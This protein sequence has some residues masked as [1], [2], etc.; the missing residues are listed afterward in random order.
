MREDASLGDQIAI[1]QLC[2]RFV[3]AYGVSHINCDLV[4]A[5]GQK[6]RALLFGVGPHLCPILA[7]PRLWPAPDRARHIWLKHKRVGGRADVECSAFLAHAIFEM[8]QR[9]RGDLLG[10]GCTERVAHV[11]LFVAHRVAYRHQIISRMKYINVSQLIVTVSSPYG[12]VRSPMTAE[13]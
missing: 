10:A 13:M 4:V 12:S 2:R 5:F 9:L 3:G 1:K 8:R 7:A 11:I 6:Q